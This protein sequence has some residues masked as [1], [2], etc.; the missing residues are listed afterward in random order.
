[1]SF[2][3][4]PSYLFAISAVFLLT[5]PGTL[6]NTAKKFLFTKKLLL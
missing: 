1:M 3:K 6:Y 2:K 5:L 4:N